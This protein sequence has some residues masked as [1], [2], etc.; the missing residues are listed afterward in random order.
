MEDFLGIN[1]Q[2]NDEDIHLIQ[3]HLIEQII[4]DLNLDHDKKTSSRI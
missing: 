2:R 4:K 3:P 1:I